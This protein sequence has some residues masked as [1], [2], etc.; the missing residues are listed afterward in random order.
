M[1]SIDLKIN[2]YNKNVQVLCHFPTKNP[3]FLLVLPLVVKSTS[4]HMCGA[5]FFEY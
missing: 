3:T 4:A 1:Y 5:P 2:K